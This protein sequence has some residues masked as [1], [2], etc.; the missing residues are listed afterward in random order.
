[1]QLVLGCRVEVEEIEGRVAHD[2]ATA[3]AADHEA[4]ERLFPDFLP[5]AQ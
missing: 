5:S 4:R 1:M 3:I 2:D